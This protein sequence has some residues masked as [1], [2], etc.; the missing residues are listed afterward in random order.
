[1]LYDFSVYNYNDDGVFDD[2]LMYGMQKTLTMTMTCFIIY[3]CYTFQ[4][5]NVILTKKM[6]MT[7]LMKCYYMLYN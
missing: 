2:I 1:M 4:K 5:K 3:C 7:C 6:T